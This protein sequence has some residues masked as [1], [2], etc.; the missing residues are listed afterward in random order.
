MSVRRLACICML[1]LGVGGAARG[2]VTSTTTHAPGAHDLDGLMSSTDLLHGLIGAELEGD[3]GWHPVNTNPDEK[4]PAFTDGAGVLGPLTGLL[5][6]FPPAGEPTKKVQYDLSGPFDISSINIFTGNIN[7]A[8]GRIFS[9]TVVRYSTN[10]GETFADLGY[11]QSDPSGSINDESGIPDGRTENK[12]TQ[13]SIFDDAA[14]L[15]AA[16]VT[17][18]QF[19]FYGVDNTQGQMRDP[20][21]GVNPF[22]G[23]DDLLTPPNT[24]PLVWEI[25]VLG[26]A[27]V[28][29]NANFNGDGAVDGKDFL[30]W[31]GGFGKIGSAV[32]ADGD[33]NSDQDVDG[34]DLAVW[35][36]QF[37]NTGLISAVPEPA[38]AGLLAGAALCGLNRRGRRR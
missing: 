10:N 37:G 23:V 3:R 1:A 26:Q 14:G 29:A 31:Q 30:I 33:A 7:N 20:F 35:R 15:V 22:T 21:D 27:A 16:S 9:T 4:L 11:F 19:N 36:G 17:N 18:L 38:T 32:L 24:S 2:A 34:D 25:D 13:V 5:N 28:A 12:I 8:D 6:D